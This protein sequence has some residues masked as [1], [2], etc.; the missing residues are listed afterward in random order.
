MNIYE[1][2]SAARLELQEKNIKKSG[3]N[4][5]AGYNY[6]ELQDFLP[7]INVIAR[8]LKFL[9]VVSF[10]AELA[11]MKIIDVEEPTHVIEFTSPMGSA[12]LKG[13][14]EVQ[15]IGAV[16][17]YQRRYLYQTAF[18]IVEHDALDST[19]NPDSK[20]VIPGKEV[21]E[22][23]HWKEES[24]KEYICSN[25]P[26]EI[27]KKVFDYSLNKFGHPLC[28]DCQKKEGK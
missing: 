25:C 6:Y 23:S 2:L 5:F 4:A 1:K 8:E 9:P 27:T 12:Q 17:S 20:D 22:E 13:C 10:T 14:H 15:N 28:M 21:K 11:T 26:K 24:A 18:E 19:M 7:V 16:E 3:K